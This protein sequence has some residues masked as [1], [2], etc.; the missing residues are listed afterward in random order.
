M[1]GK[2]GRPQEDRLLRQRQIF[3]AVAPLILEVGA[4]ELTMR[5][6]AH[7]ASMSIGGLYHYFP[8]KRDLVLHSLD[9]EAHDRLCIDFNT[10]YG[11][12]EQTDP[13]AYL[14]AFIEFQAHAAAFLRPALHAAIELGA[15]TVWPTLERAMSLGLEDWVRIAR[16]VVPDPGERDLEALC[17]AVR[18]TML[19]SM[20][21]KT[22][23]PVELT[24]A[25]RALIV[26]EPVGLR[27]A[28][29]RTA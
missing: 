22:V 24:E 8:S 17:R 16:R 5:Q 10:I 25:L 13:D 6:A 23:T 19:G 2:V 12:L 28:W 11:H 4:R 14:A 21:D 29:A 3:E 20:L 27:R 9:P 26:G 15:E 7:R 18:R 1:F